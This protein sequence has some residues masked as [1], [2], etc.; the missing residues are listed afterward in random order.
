METESRPTVKGIGVLAGYIKCT[1]LVAALSGSA[2][3]LSVWE[4]SVSDFFAGT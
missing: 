1:H 4:Y 2:G 3:L